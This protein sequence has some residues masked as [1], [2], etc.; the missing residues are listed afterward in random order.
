MREIYDLRSAIEVLRDNEGQLVETSVEA[1]PNAEISGIYRYVGAGGTVMRPTR[2]DG[3]AMLFN[4][5]KGFPDCRVIT[6]VLASRKRVG[7]LLDADYKRLGWHLRDAVKNVIPPIIKESA[8]VC[9]ENVYLASDPD[10]D[11]RKL[12]PAPTNTPEDAGPYIT[13]GL[14]SATDPED[15]NITDVTIHR[16][17]IQSRDEMTMWITPGSR[18]IGA[19]WDKALKMNKPLPISVSIGLDPAI[20]MCAGFE[21]PTTPYGFNELQ[22]AGALRGKPVE[23][24]RCVS[25][26]ETCIAHAEYVI[27]GELIPGRTMREDINS[28]TGKAMP[29]FPGYTGEAKGDDLPNYLPVIKVKA[30]TTRNNPIM[31]SCIGPSHEHV[32]MAGIPTEA[33]VIDLVERA[34]PGRL[35]NVHAAPCGG[36]KFVT[37]I[38]FRKNNIND[39]GRQRQA[40]LLAFSAFSEMKHVFLVDE[41]VDIFDMSDVMWAMTTRF[42]GDVDF[43]P[44]PGVHTHVLDPSNDPK[45]APSIA[46][47]G[48]ACK[49][50]FDCTVP[51][52]MK[53]E[54]ERC[55][56]LEVDPKKWLPDFC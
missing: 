54:F 20:Y 42:Q 41:D 36:G 19:M 13:M 1:D 2:E 24:A 45:Y 34:M 18:H 7:L 32:S 33:S 29:E 17:C 22:I 50:I 15:R 31:E 30:V 46:V 53:N 28:N 51:Y 14:C 47:H 48:I 56:F 26:D 9:Q 37:I 52:N 27:E 25:I 8:P 40:A 35:V 6:G 44:I 10:F 4:N 21:P 43:I 23:L 12:V 5:V 55:K 39:E 38:Q 16:L 11:L 49:S 3:P